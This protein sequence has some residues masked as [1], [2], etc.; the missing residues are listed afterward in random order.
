MAEEALFFSIQQVITPGDGVPQGLLA[1]RPV[2]PTTGQEFQALFQA[3]QHGARRQ[4]LNPGSGQLDRQG[5]P[6]QPGADLGHGKRRLG[7]ELKVRLDR[8]GALD[9]QLDGRVF[10]Q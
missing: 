4:E 5:Q 6:I 1:R 10:R 9:K 7:C 3:G 8:L 2:P